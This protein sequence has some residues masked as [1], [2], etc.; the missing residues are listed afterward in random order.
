MAIALT[1]RAMR[2][3]LEASLEGTLE[4]EADLQG[5]AGRT[6]DHGEG[7]AAFI[8]KRSPRFEGE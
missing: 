3:A 4:Y 1:K 2:R 6:R 8:E 7:I 5:V